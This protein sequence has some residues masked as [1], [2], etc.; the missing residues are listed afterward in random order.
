MSKPLD[1]ETLAILNNYGSLLNNTGGNDPAEL[2]LDFFNHD[3]NMFA[4]NIVRYVLAM[5]VFAQVALIKTLI[6]EGLL[7]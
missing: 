7:R 5:A 6:R 3:K 2:L 1:E 4:T